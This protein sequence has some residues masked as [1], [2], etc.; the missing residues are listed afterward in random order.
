[1]RALT[2]DW[3]TE[4]RRR[5]SC[6]H[7]DRLDEALEDIALMQA[8]IEQLQQENADRPASVHVTASLEGQT[9][10][11]FAPGAPITFTASL[12]GQTMSSFAPGAPIT[13]TA[14]TDNAEGVALTT[15]TSGQPF[16]YTWTTSA[17]TIVTGADTSVI[18]ISDAPLGDV[19]ATATNNVGLVSLPCDATVADQTPATVTVTAS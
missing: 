17:G 14:A 9:M 5:I 18:T 13:F 8:E 10:S 2:S 19:A 3:F 1:M 6:W 12:E 11:S 15:D 4:H 16:T 7:E